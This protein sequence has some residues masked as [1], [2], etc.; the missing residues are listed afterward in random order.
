[1]KIN[2]NKLWF[3]LK[4]C[5]IDVIEY[6]IIYKEMG[7]GLVFEFLEY[8]DFFFFNSCWLLLVLWI[9]WGFIVGFMLINVLGG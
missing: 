5:C 8:I 9:G 2:N 1:M 3:Y 7:S 4:Y 6:E